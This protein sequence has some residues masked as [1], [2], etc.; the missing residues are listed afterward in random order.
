MALNIIPL[1]FSDVFNALPIDQH[2]K[3]QDDGLAFTCDLQ[4]VDNVPAYLDPSHVGAWILGYLAAASEHENK[5][6]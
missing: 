1:S 4:G 2:L 3:P 5:E 6:S